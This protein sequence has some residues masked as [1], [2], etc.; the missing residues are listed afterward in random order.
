MKNK[1]KTFCTLLLGLVF[2]AGASCADSNN[3]KSKKK[4]GTEEN[5]SGSG[6]VLIAYF[7]VTGNTRSVA[8]KVQK[9]VASDYGRQV[10]IYEIIPEDPY[11]KEDLN[12]N[13][14]NCRANIECHDRTIRPAIKGDLPSL[15]SYQV[16]IIASPIWWGLPPN[17]VYTFLE[18]YRGSGKEGKNETAF[19]GKSVS[20]FCT[21]GGS[22]VG[23]SKEVLE[24]AIG[25]GVKLTTCERLKTSITDATLKKFIERCR[26]VKANNT[27]EAEGMKAMNAKKIK[28]SV[29]NKSYNAT[30]KEN[31]SARQFY[32]ILKKNSITLDMHDYGDFEKS[33][34][35]G[36]NITREDTLTKTG[37]WDFILYQGH[38]IAIYYGY[39]EY[40]FTL[41][42]QIEGA[43]KSNMEEFLGRGGGNRKV[44]FSID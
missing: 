29:G 28:I 15:S 16:V 19:R 14:D 33:G 2:I 44:K 3:S 17:I 4:E 18:G 39:N 25:G 7:S 36:Q 22:G 30:L 9:L 6:K 40:D 1:V 41:L 35:L 43:N 20:Y 21:S 23:N 26:I 32:E 11:T 8:N 5:K 27:E 38:I 31:K 37:P 10:D 12:Y 42:G 24:E 34:D 13:N